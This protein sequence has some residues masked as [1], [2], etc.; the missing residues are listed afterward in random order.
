MRHVKGPDF[1]TG[2]DHRRPLRASATPTARAAAA[3]SCAARAHIEELRGGKTAII[4]TEL[5]YG[6]K[7]GG[8]NGVI[9]K[10]ADLVK[11]KVLTE[12]TAARG[13]LRQVRDADPDRAQ[14]R[15]RSRRSC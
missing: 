10:I 8:D 5:P 2:G 12:I 9:A 6:V 4:V 7:K 15:R 11:D 13:P 3:S 14:A 1:P